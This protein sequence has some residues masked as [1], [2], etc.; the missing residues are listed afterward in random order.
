MMPGKPTTDVD[1]YFDQAKPYIKALVENQLKE[2]GSAKIMLILWVLWKKPI[3]RLI[4]LG[5]D[6][7]TDEIY[8]GKI[9]MPFNSLMTEFFDASDIDEVS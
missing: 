7:T 2:M 9:D 8:N 4:K 5:P 6:D 3:K 1:S